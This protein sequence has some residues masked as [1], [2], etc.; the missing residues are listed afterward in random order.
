MSITKIFFPKNLLFN[1]G[2]NIGLGFIVFEQL[3][4]LEL[5]NTHKNELKILQFRENRRFQFLNLK[6]KI[7]RVSLLK[8]SY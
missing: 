1:T 2:K 3:I 5:V 6:I 7:D 4:S 8:K